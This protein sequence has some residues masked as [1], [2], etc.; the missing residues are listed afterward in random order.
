MKTI[1]FNGRIIC[2]DS[3]IP[4]GYIAIE[5]GVITEIGLGGPTQKSSIR[6]SSEGAHW[7]DA[8]EHFISPG[9]IDLHVHGVGVCDIYND[10]VRGIKKMSKVLA[11]QGVTSFLPTFITAPFEKTL[12]VISK[13]TSFNEP[14]PG[15]HILGINIEGPFLNPEK[16]GAHPLKDIR[17]PNL[18]ELKKIFESSHGKL[19]MMTIAPE[20]PGAMELVKYLNE[21]GVIPAMGHTMA[22]YEDT[23]CA[24]EGGIHYICHLFNAMTPF[25]HRAPGPL[26]A[27][28]I[29]SDVSV[30]II[31]DGLHLHPAVIKLLYN[32]KEREKIILVTDAL[33]GIMRKGDK[34]EFA[35]VPIVSNGIGAYNIDNILM[36]SVTPMNRAI[37]NIMNFAGIS[38]ISAVKLATTNPA[39]IL[40]IGNKKGTIEVGKDGDL[41]IFG[42]DFSIKST[43]ISGKA[44]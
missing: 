16:R 15:A 1:V 21:N 26:P 30:E 10:P 20:M 38:L 7:I 11:S 32:I 14:I 25:H 4:R 23:I 28:V 5:D 12:E 33:S 13:I 37:Q 27:V 6:P 29:K 31:A 18:T 3:I 42:E 41:V 43:I 34:A 39:N 24:L 2:P 36:G 19:K 9:F 17:H 44:I 8:E 40:G 22:S 35:G